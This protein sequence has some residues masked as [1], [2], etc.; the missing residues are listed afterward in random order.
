[1]T[2]HDGTT[3]PLAGYMLQLSQCR[4][5]QKIYTKQLIFTLYTADIL[6]VS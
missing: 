4:I 6:V 2:L 5:L 3:V 1:M